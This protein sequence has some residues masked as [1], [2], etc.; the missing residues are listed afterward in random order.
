MIAQEESQPGGMEF[1]PTDYRRSL[2]TPRLEFLTGE[3][4][5]RST[6]DRNHPQ[7]K[8]LSPETDRTCSNGHEPDSIPCSSRGMLVI[9]FELPHI[10]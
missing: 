3:D 6:D 8:L 7:A 2:I 10:L 1:K 5:R 9:V 4:A